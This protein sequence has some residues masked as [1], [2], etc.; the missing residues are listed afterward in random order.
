MT[1]MWWHR[2]IPHA[3]NVRGWKITPSHY[4]NQDLASVWLAN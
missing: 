3:A 2:I 4:V 1:A